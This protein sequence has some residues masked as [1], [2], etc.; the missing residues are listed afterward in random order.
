MNRHSGQHD[1]RALPQTREVRQ[2]HSTRR[3]GEHKLKNDFPSANRNNKQQQNL[4]ELRLVVVKVIP[5]P[6]T[7]DYPINV[8]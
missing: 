4:R 7:N 1:E 2:T 8:N 6:V 5:A 3:R